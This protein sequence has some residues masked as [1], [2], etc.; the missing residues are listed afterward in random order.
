[1]KRAFFFYCCW[2]LFKWCIYFLNSSF[3]PFAGAF[4]PFE[5][6][7]NTIWILCIFVSGPSNVHHHNSPY[8]ESIWIRCNP[9]I[10][11]KFNTNQHEMNHQTS[12]YRTDI[13]YEYWVKFWFMCE[14]VIFGEWWFIFNRLVDTSVLL[15]T[16]SSSRFIICKF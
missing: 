8:N 4:S 11:A 2:H 6:S 3:P 12:N 14:I 5:F 10:G 7:I 1:M 16:D 15:L 9:I 13:D